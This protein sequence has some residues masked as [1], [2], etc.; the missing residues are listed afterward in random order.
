MV[1]YTATKSNHGSWN[2]WIKL[3][4]SSKNEW[5][6]EDLQRLYGVDVSTKV[7]YLVNNHALTKVNDV[8][9]LPDF[10]PS[11]LILLQEI[12][13]V[14]QSFYDLLI[15]VNSSQQS[16]ER[17]DK[18]SVNFENQLFNLLKTFANSTNSKFISLAKNELESLKPKL[19]TELI[20]ST[21]F[22][23]AEKLLTESIFDIHSLFTGILDTYFSQIHSLLLQMGADANLNSL[24]AEQKPTDSLFPTANLQFEQF[25]SNLFEAM[26]LFNLQSK[27]TISS[28]QNISDTLESILLDVII[29][30]IISFGEK[31]SSTFDHS[32]IDLKKTFEKLSEE[33]ITEISKS[34]QETKDGIRNLIGSVFSINKSVI[35]KFLSSLDVLADG[36]AETKANLSKALGKTHR[37]VKIQVMFSLK[38]LKNSAKKIKAMH[39][40]AKGEFQSE[41]LTIIKNN[42]IF[43]DAIL[44]EVKQGTAIFEDDFLKFL[45]SIQN[46]LKFSAGYLQ[47]TPEVINFS[48]SVETKLFEMKSII[49]QILAQKLSSAGVNILDSDFDTL[50]TGVLLQFKQGIH[51]DLHQVSEQLALVK[52]SQDAVINQQL[53]VIFAQFRVGIQKVME[54]FETNVTSRQNEII[55]SLNQAKQSM[56]TTLTEMS[57]FSYSSITSVLTKLELFIKQENP[58]IFKQS[59]TKLSSV[60]DVLSSL[61]KTIEKLTET[62]SDKLDEQITSSERVLMTEV[63]SL[64]LAILNNAQTKLVESQRRFLQNVENHKDNISTDI[65]KIRIST[66]LEV[67]ERVTYLIK[68]LSQLLEN[69]DEFSDS[70]R[71]IVKKEINELQIAS[72]QQNSMVNPM[73]DAANENLIQGFQGLLN[74]AREQFESIE[75]KAKISVQ[76]RVNEIKTESKVKAREVIGASLPLLLQK[77]METTKISDLADKLGTVNEKTIMNKIGNLASEIKLVVDDNA[78][79]VSDKAILKPKDIENMKVLQSQLDRLISSVLYR[80]E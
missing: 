51:Q 22:S 14:A 43:L 72:N 71:K 46:N 39:D 3:V 75:E 21:V 45:Q 76:E 11:T 15:R 1:K 58:S 24:K 6:A 4:Q 70:F 31:M 20:T 9:L 8:F 65:N 40:K 77:E 36:V 30:K 80:K 52:Q 35:D 10:P 33:L 41:I 42:Q 37:S 48:Q 49:L 34:E 54:V 57:K 2:L 18:R 62:N 12:Q 13:T 63:E 68:E 67:Q 56:T 32:Y 73:I 19:N 55:S 66:H 64:R 38:K 16:E 26:D 25:T 28:Q 69:L 78:M 5:T 53:E 29:N 60:L 44:E 27:K 23:D 79:K 50:L 74:N 61:I 17:K 47:S 59:L 7:T